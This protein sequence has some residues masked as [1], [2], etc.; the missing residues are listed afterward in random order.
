MNRPTYQKGYVSDPIRTNRGLKFII[1]YREWTSEGRW[2]HKA[3]TLYGLSGKKAAQAVL[4]ERI[5][6]QSTEKTKTS[7]LTFP[8]FIDTFWKPYLERRN[9][10]VSTLQGYE[11]PLRQHITPALGEL[12]LTDIAPLHDEQLLQS[13]SALPSVVT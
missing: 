2:R 3:E 1:R 8:Q 7:K 9:V 11:F 4:D 12:M 6:E 5:R 13:K 10:K